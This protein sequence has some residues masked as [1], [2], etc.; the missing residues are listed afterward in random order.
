[1]DVPRVAG[2]TCAPPEEHPSCYQSAEEKQR[3]HSNHDSREYRVHGNLVATSVLVRKTAVRPSAD[4]MESTATQNC[5]YRV[6][7]DHGARHC[8]QVL[9]PL[10]H[11]EA[12]DEAAQSCDRIAHRVRCWGAPVQREGMKW[13]I[14]AS[15]VVQ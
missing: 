13:E 10:D 2:N 1:M 15:V 6:R 9:S 12:C 5:E 14:D 8:K 4:H 3:Q 7:D 11:L